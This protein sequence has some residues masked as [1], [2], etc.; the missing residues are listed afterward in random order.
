MTRLNSFVDLTARTAR[1]QWWLDH[2]FKMSG[3]RPLKGLTKAAYFVWGLMSS[4]YDSLRP[5][6]TNYLPPAEALATAENNHSLPFPRKISVNPAGFSFAT[7]ARDSGAIRPITNQVRELIPKEKLREMVYVLASEKPFFTREELVRFLEEKLRQVYRGPLAKVGRLLDE[8]VADQEIKQTGQFYHFDPKD[9]HKISTAR[10]RVDSFFRTFKDE[11]DSRIERLELCDNHESLWN[12]IHDDRANLGF[13]GVYLL[14]KV[15]GFKQVR[16]TSDREPL[17]KEEAKPEGV[18]KAVLESDR[19]VHRIEIGEELD[20][21]LKNFKAA[22]L[23]E[24]DPRWI[25]ESLLKYGIGA[26]DLL[27]LTDGSGNAVGVLYLRDP[28]YF[29]EEQQL[30]VDN[31]LAKLAEAIGRTITRLAEKKKTAAQAP[32][33]E[34]KSELT[35]SQKAKNEE[36]ENLLR[37]LNERKK[38][39]VR[40]ADF[41]RNGRSFKDY[42]IDKPAQIVGHELPTLLHN[43]NSIWDGLSIDFLKKVILRSTKIKF[44]VENTVGHKMAVGYSIVTRKEKG[45]YY[46]IMAAH[47]QAQQLRFSTRDTYEFVK[48]AFIEDASQAIVPRLRLFNRLRFWFKLGCAF[49]YAKGWLSRPPREFE[50]IK[51]RVAYLTDTDVGLAPLYQYIENV[52]P[53]PDFIPGKSFEPSAEVL[54]ALLPEGYE[55]IRILLEINGNQVPVYVV[56]SHEPRQKGEP[57]KYAKN[58]EVAKLVRD[59][60]STKTNGLPEGDYDL[61][62]CLEIDIHDFHRYFAL[63]KTG[64]KVDRTTRSTL[65]NI[66]SM[67]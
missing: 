58:A 64:K 32:A 43:L 2:G 18:M 62:V 52:F 53:R 3:D 66:S 67:V 33:I 24:A 7:S 8:L 36:T 27:R 60:R 51:T 6:K 22:G 12:I 23:T 20:S 31:K 11:I 50:N 14:Q 61:L 15:N 26:I 48:E 16:Y 42:T 30:V 47:E 17:Y 59:A 29:G 39:G 44:K 45:T 34:N 10:D 38:A 63:N 49:L 21:T 35:V 55:P 40:V 13:R 41:T 54:K 9:P 19:V 25:E 37:M 57:P 56:R 46:E 28:V 1:N 65:S 4:A 5:S